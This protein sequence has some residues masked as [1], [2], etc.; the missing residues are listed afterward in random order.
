MI[1]VLVVP[2]DQN[3]PMSVIAIEAD[4][5]TLQGMV[6]GYIEAFSGPTWVGYC[7]EEGKIN[8][9]L[10]NVRATQLA[11]AARW[12]T[13]DVLM[14]DVV[15]VGPPD[16]EGRDTDVPQSLVWIANGMG[17]SLGGKAKT[18]RGR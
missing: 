13:L 8:G 15:F 18:R 5:E 7:N 6:G 9:L 3:E 1:A 17:S 12:G 14:G 4:L 11:R 16:E 10:P 2:A